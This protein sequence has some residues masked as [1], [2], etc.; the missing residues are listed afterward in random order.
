MAR[1]NYLVL[2]QTRTQ[3]QTR[4]G[5]PALPGLRQSGRAGTCRSSRKKRSNAMTNGTMDIA[6]QDVR[7]LTMS[8]VDDVSGA[9]FPLLIMAFAIG[10]DIGFITTMALK[11]LPP[12]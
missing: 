8:E 2:K 6:Q 12:L 3:S 7:E 4:R 5:E 9:F 11:P 1:R 10:F